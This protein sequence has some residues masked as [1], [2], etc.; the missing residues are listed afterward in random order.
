M[1]ITYS[2]SCWQMGFY[3]F[4]SLR[5]WLAL[6][7]IGCVDLREICKICQC[8]MYVNKVLSVVRAAPWIVAAVDTG[9]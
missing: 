6:T 1:R 5:I 8:L 9:S 7:P 3:N 4:A 2:M